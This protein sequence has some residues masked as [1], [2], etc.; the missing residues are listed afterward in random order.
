MTDTEV[1]DEQEYRERL[2][3][4]IA[5]WTRGGVITAEQERVDPRAHRRG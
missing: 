4:D 3:H 2:A 1:M 5:T